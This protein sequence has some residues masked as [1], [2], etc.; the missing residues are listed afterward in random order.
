MFF[1]HDFYG[2]IVFTPY[3]GLIFYEEEMSV[4]L[5]VCQEQKK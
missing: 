1:Y 5:Y 3:L 2:F 4:R